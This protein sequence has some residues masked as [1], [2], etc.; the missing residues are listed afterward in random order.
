MH[1]T[2][3]TIAELPAE[4][5]IQIAAVIVAACQLFD[6]KTSSIHSYDQVPKL[7]RI[8]GL[9]IYIARKHLGETFVAIS[10]H[11]NRDTSTIQN[12]YRGVLSRGVSSEMRQDIEDI[13]EVALELQAGPPDERKWDEIEVPRGG[14]LRYKSHELRPVHAI[15]E[16][17]SP[18]WFQSCDEAYRSA[19]IAALWQ[20]KAERDAARVA[21]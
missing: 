17:A 9:I 1:V 11:M 4:P 8:R 13:L 18:E 14:Q 12:A 19:M 20:A 21:A 6:V 16:T 7:S 2:T 10:A 3:E 5:K 15:G